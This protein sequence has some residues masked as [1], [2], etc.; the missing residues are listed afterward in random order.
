MS[1]NGIVV[2]GCSACFAN[3]ARCE[4]ETFDVGALDMVVGRVDIFTWHCFGF[5][6]LLKE[7]LNVFGV[8][9]MVALPMWRC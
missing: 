6:A 9:R 3:D 5:Y 4:R 8:K 1:G 2:V 7:Q